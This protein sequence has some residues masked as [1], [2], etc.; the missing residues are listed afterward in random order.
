MRP[1]LAKISTKL[2][3]NEAFVKAALAEHLEIAEEAAEKL[4]A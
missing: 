2:A 1:L 3:K 4:L